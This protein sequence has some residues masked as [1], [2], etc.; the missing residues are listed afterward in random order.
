MEKTNFSAL[1]IASTSLSSGI[2]RNP[3]PSGQGLSALPDVSALRDALS[4]EKAYHL[5]LPLIGVEF[6][7]RRAKSKAPAL[8]FRAESP[9]I[10]STGQSPVKSGTSEQ[11]AL[12]GRNPVIDSMPPFQGYGGRVATIIHRALPCATDYR[13]FSP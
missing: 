10:N 11:P 4:V 7:L 3:S 13:A 12:K 8:R 1:G 5:P 6:T 9:A 2:V